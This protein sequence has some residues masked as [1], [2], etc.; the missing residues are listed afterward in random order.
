M[1][2]TV[3]FPLLFLAAAAG[4]MGYVIK[5]ELFPGGRILNPYFNWLS[6]WV[7]P[8][9]RLYNRTPRPYLFKP[10]GDCLACFSG[11]L[12][13]WAYVLSLPRI[14]AFH[15]GHAAL[16]VCF[17]IVVAIRLNKTTA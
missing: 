13:L 8:E 17:S 4:L 5:T 3:F 12:A 16:V 14:Q 2:P 7:G 15:P 10:L 9:A 11:Q 6:R 1:E